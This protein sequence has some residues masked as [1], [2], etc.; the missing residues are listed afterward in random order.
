LSRAWCEIQYDLTQRLFFLDFLGQNF[1]AME[2]RP[3]P[4]QIT[5]TN[6]CGLKTGKISARN[7]FQDRKNPGKMATA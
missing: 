2:V 4:S 6:F 5:H 7:I 1:C 3:R